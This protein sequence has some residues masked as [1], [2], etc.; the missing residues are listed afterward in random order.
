MQSND[1]IDDGG[2]KGTD[3]RFEEDLYDNEKDEDGD[4]EYGKGGE[5]YENE[6]V[7]KNDDDYE[8][9]EKAVWRELVHCSGC[10]WLHVGIILALSST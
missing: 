5:D 1:D 10:Q 9:G 2:Y 4:D 3:I 7:D 6:N 8:K